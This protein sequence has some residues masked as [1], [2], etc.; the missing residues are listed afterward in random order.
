[1][2]VLGI[3]DGIH[4]ASACLVDEQG[5]RMAVSEERLNREKNTGGWPRQ[6]VAS[7]L[8][9]SDVD[10]IDA[11]HLAGCRNPHPLTRWFRVGQKF[12]RTTGGSIFPPQPGPLLRLAEMAQMHFLGQPFAPTTVPTWLNWKLH[13]EMP[14]GLRRKP[15]KFF[16]HHLCHAASAYMTSSGEPLLIIV[17]DGVGDGCSFSVWRGENGLL[18]VLHRQG[19]SSSLA[20]LFGYFT[21]LF[22]LQPFKDEGKLM[23]YAAQGHARAIEL[24]FPLKASGGEI[25]GTVPLGRQFYH[26]FG[27]LRQSAIADVAAWLQAGAQTLLADLARYWMDQTAIKQLGVAGGLFR[28]VL[29]NLAIIEQGKPDYLHIVPPMGDEG[30][31]LGAAALRDGRICCSQEI[32]TVFW[33]PNDSAVQFT[34]IPDDLILVTETELTAAVADN[35]AQ[36]KTVGVWRGASEFGPR[37]L[38]N[39]SILFAADATSL[40]ENMTARLERHPVMPYA[41]LVLADDFAELFDGDYRKTNGFRFMTLAARARTGVKDVYPVAVHLDGTARVQVVEL[42]YQPFLATVLSDY[43]KKTGKKLIIN[44]SFNHHSE[45]IIETAE[46]ALASFKRCGLDLLLLGDRLYRLRCEAK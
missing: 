22:G 31:C 26:R 33:G 14:P 32:Q 16:D 42:E 1:M 11:I 30:T 29:I 34:N 17:A 15:I 35:L 37:A 45:P 40:A 13:Q 10:N 12:F 7:I 2:A 8:R 46:D 27:Q 20:F 39:R 28:N 18:T 25:M 3:I 9:N 44:T 21:S 24:S 43:R 6:A 19:A 41:P 38:G 23:A 5:V 36:G 4:N